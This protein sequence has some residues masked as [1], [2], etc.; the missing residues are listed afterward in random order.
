[1]DIVSEEM[2]VF[3]SSRSLVQCYLFYG[4]HAPVSNYHSYINR[5]KSSKESQNLIKYI[6]C[7]LYL[8]YDKLIHFCPVNLRADHLIHQRHSDPPLQTL[9]EHEVAVRSIRMSDG[10]RHIL[11]SGTK[12]TDLKVGQNVHFCVGVCGAGQR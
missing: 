8:T 4:V 6:S 2:G 12:L 10:N 3:V 9:L 1:M 11:T 5:A 7:I